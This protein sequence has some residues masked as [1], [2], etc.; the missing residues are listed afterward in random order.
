MFDFLKHSPLIEEAGRARVRPRLFGQLLI[1][2]LVSFVV[3]SAATLISSFYLT[4]EMLK[5]LPAL[6]D[7]S[8]EAYEA[9]LNEAMGP[10]MASDTFLLLSLFGTVFMLILVPVYC[11]CIEKRPLSSL[12]VRGAFLPEYGK[13]MLFGLLMMGGAF[14]ICYASGAVSV[15]VTAGQLNIGLILL[16][17]LAFLIQGAAEEILMRGYFTVSLTNSVSPAFAVFTG[18][19]FF[20]ALHSSNLGYGIFPFV[21]TFLFGLLLSFYMFKSGSIFGACALHGVFNFAEGLLFGLPVS[22]MKMGVS[23][24][25]STVNEEMNLTNG[26]L[27]GPEGGCAVTLVLLVAF[28]LFFY[29]PKKKESNSVENA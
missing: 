25:S 7:V 23:V 8:L 20:A 5:G 22:G 19:A 17:L 9:Y 13:G 11:C 4:A 18:A 27:Y 29:F 12:G 10:I 2:W 3:E 6:G 21:N 26:G 28:L 24:L 14:L 15:T 16:Y 1:F